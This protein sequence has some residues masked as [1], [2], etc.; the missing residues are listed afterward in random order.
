MDGLDLLSIIKPRKD[1][2]PPPFGSPIMEKDFDNL[3]FNSLLKTQSNINSNINPFLL[4]LCGPP[5]CGKSTVKK[6]LLNEIGIV[7][8][9]DIDPDEIRTNLMSQGFGVTFSDDKIMSGVTNAFNERMSSEAK[10]QGL[11]IVFDTTGQ[12][13]SAVK[14]LINSSKTFNYYACFSVIWAS[15]ETCVLR[16]E[17]RNILLQ[18]T[19]SGRIQLPIEIVNSIYDG[20][21]RPKGTASMFLLDYPISANEIRLY[22]NNSEGVQPD[23]LYQ[24]IENSVVSARD[25]NGFYNMNIHSMEP[26][27]T[28]RYSGGKNKKSKLLRKSRKIRKTKKPMK[29][30]KIKKHTKTKTRKF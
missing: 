3:I 4:I 8:Y 23:L 22:S 13:Y 29:T 28:K 19:N 26:Y 1:Y 11:N 20:F 25:F 6:Q 7:N 12:N 9:I 10:R 18:N 5:G 17:N 30:M 24:K 15:K 14:D 27:I 16:V 21:I 2:I